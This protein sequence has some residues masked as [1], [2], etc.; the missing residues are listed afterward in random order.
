M[1]V[2]TLVLFSPA[3]PFPFLLIDYS[4][5]PNIPAYETD[6]W[7]VHTSIPNKP[8]GETFLL[9]LLQYCRPVFTSRR[10]TLNSTAFHAS[11]KHFR[12]HI[13]VDTQSP[14][15]PFSS[16]T[17]VSPALSRCR[18]SSVHCGR[19]YG[20]GTRPRRRRDACLRADTDRVEPF[21]LFGQPPWSPSARCCV[22]N[23]P[24]PDSSRE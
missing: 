11:W 22:C 16:P 15:Q 7:L 18:H 13:S 14:P 17:C 5:T 1:A 2:S 9:I 21:G 24:R 20:R 6:P 19:G 12:L 4:S 10:L 3:S 8:Q 23:P